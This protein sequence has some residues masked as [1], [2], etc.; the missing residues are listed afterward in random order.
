MN[1]YRTKL[2][3]LV[4]VILLS[5]CSKSQPVAPTTTLPPPTATSIPTETPTATP[6]EVPTETPIPAPTQDP[7]IFGAILQTETQAFSL[8]PVANAIFT[9]TMDGFIA[10]GIIT[11]YQ[12]THVTIF[13]GNGGLLAEIYFNVRSANAMWL[14]DGGTQAADNWINDKCNR[15]D[16]ITT[17]TEFQLK[18]RRM[19]S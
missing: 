10:S 1:I 8:E 3:L 4:F 12:V 6:T 5:A 7:L 19:C 17:D 18:N 2:L 16:F 13:P 11:E 9:K 15:F 14:E